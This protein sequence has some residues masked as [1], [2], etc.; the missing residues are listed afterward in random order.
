MGEVTNR[1]PLMA[2]GVLL[3]IG[4][5]GFADGILFHQIL[6]V[7]NMLSAKY[8]R[9]GVDVATALVN[10]E[11]NMFWDGLFHAFTWGM[12]A[13]GLASLWRATARPDVPHSTRTLVGSLAMGWG[14]FN[15][16][17]GLIDH[18]I[19]RIHH[20]VE[21]GNHP[22][23]DALFL[24]SGGAL[25]LAGWVVVGAGRVDDGPNAG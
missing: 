13:I 17:E 7:H 20:V 10:V 14:A 18:E 9:S 5:G 21:D 3:G 6:Q 24:A 12:T 2:A 4:L 16:V 15:L 1:R 19:M 23:W 22:L 8:P 25:L 11:I